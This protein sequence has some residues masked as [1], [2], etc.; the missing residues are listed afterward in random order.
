MVN[1]VLAR[2]EVSAALLP[3]HPARRRLTA[4][5]PGGRPARQPATLQT[6]TDASEQNDTGP[7]YSFYFTNTW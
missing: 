4:H 6:K 3:T 2:R 7:L 1:K 5:V